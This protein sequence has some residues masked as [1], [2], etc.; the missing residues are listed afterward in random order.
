MMKKSILIFKEGDLIGDN[1]L[2][3][4]KELPYRLKND[5]RKRRMGLFRCT[6]GSEFESGIIGVKHLVHFKTKEQAVIARNDYIITNNLMEYKI[7]EVI[8]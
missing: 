5:G 2:I 3:L 7:Q 6:C 4:L 8:K 1:G